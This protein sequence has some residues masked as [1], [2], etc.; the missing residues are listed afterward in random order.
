MFT[1]V[2]LYNYRSLNNVFFNLKETKDKIKKLVAVYG[3]NGC[4]KSNLIRSFYFL[5]R[6][7]HSF[8]IEQNEI[9]LTEFLNEKGKN[10][11][12]PFFFEIFRKNTVSNIYINSRTVDCEDSTRIEFGF[13]IEGHEG[14]Y[15]IEFKET[16]SY[17]KLYYFTG[18]QNGLIFEIEKDLIKE[19][20]FA[21]LIFKTNKIKKELKDL[22]LKYWG[23]HSMLAITFDMLKKLNQEY[24]KENI[25]PYLFDFHNMISETSVDLKEGNGG[26]MISSSKHINFISNFEKGD[27]SIENEWLLDNTEKIINDFFTQTYSDIKKVFF[28]TEKEEKRIKYH[29]MFY[30]NINDKIR[31]IPVEQEST[32][33]R[34]IL[35]ILRNLFGVFCGCTVIIDEVDNGVH[36]LLLKV[37]IESMKDYITGQLIFTT[38][39]T[40]LLE[41]LDPKMVYII[42]G[43]Y[44]GTKEIICLS[45]YK[46]QDHNSPRVRYMKGL[47]GGIPFVDSVDYLEIISKLKDDNCEFKE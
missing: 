5:E 43:N 3:E 19:P 28:K 9:E 47:Y 40:S 24:M 45:D 26:A 33:T 10:N 14:Y 42:N 32:G 34:Q 22:I 46:I 44:D 1:Y 35:N 39:N 6:L 8:D 12:P 38:H 7:M 18:N 15:I 29:L 11:I 37:I 17:E 31:L 13:E 16:I 21:P 25:S 23:R 36:D 30:K 20:K 41:S 27:I 2:K 4:G